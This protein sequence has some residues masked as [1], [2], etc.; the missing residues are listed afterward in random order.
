MPHTYTYRL[1]IDESGDHS[2]GKKEL[3]TFRIVSKE[4]TTVAEFPYENFPELEDISKR[5]LGLTGCIVETNEYRNSFHP[6]LEKLKQ[7]HFPHNPDDPVILHRKDIINKSGS[8]WRLREPERERAFNDDLLS[9]IGSMKYKVITVVIDKKEHVERYQGFAYHPYHYCMAALLERYCG[10]LQFYNAKG[11][12][13]AE[14][15]GGAE[16]KQFK[17]AYRRIYNSGTQFRQSDFFC[18][19][20][21]SKEIKLKPKIANIAGLQLSDILAYPLKQEILIENGRCSAPGEELFGSKVC[22]IINKDK[23]NRHVYTGR[24]HGYGKVF[25]K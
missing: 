12:V 8:F 5:Y 7:K 4:R 1:Y 2:Y 25:L 17:E 6:E 14:S 11:D 3:R 16:D 15:R 19:V 24:I 23:Y 13:L 9:F 18:K 20:L 22:E 21:T 10:F